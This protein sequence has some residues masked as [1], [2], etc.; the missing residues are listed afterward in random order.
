MTY[1]LSKYLAV[2]SNCSHAT[3][4][5]VAARPWSLEGEFAFF[6]NINERTAFHYF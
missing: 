2:I 6:E 1:L 5:I 3:H 4:V